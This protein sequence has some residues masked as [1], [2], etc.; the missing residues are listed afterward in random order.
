MQLDA[1]E[2]RDFKSVCHEI[3]RG[4]GALEMLRCEGELSEMGEWKRYI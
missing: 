4:E 2:S 1:I 3:L